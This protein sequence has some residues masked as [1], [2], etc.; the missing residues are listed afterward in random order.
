MAPI[1]QSWNLDGPGNWEE[2]VALSSGIPL[3]EARV[4]TSS[5]E[6]VHV[7][8]GLPVDLTYDSKGNLTS[9][10]TLAYQWDYRDRLRRVTREVDGVVIAQYAYDAIGRRVRKDVADSGGQRSIE[11][12]TYGGWQVLEEQD[13]TGVPVQTYTYGSYIG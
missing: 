1:H 12:Y 10:G 6:L 11:Y 13:A 9:D 3:T 5:N 4:H 2:V 8:G 7:E